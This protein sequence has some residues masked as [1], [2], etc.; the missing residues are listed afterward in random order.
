MGEA[1]YD[2][3]VVGGGNV[4]LVMGMYLTKYGGAET[5]ILEERNELGGSWETIENASPGYMSSQHSF[6]HATEWWRLPTEEDFPEFI[7]YGAKNLTH[8]GMAIAVP[9]NDGTATGIYTDALDP[10][11]ERTA[12]L[13][14]RYSQKDAETWMNF[15]EAW[16]KI[17]E[18]VNEAFCTVP[19]GRNPM[20]GPEGV[21]MRMLMD[22]VCQKVLDPQYAYMTPHNA[23]QVFFEAPE[24]QQLP[25][26]W[27][28]SAGMPV[29]GTGQGLMS[30]VFGMGMAHVMGFVKGG[31]HNCAHAAQRVIKENGGEYLT[32]S[33]V[34]D[35][36]MENGEAAGVRLADGTEIMARKGVVL[37]GMHPRQV[38]DFLGRDNV[39]PIIQRKVASLL[40]DSCLIYWSWFVLQERP[41]FKSCDQMGLPELD[42]AQWICPSGDPKDINSLVKQEHLRGLGEPGPFPSLDPNLNL[43]CIHGEGDPTLIPEDG[44]FLQLIEQHTVPAYSRDERWWRKYHEDMRDACLDLLEKYTTNVNRKSLVGYAPLS[45]W[46]ITRLRNF[47]YEGNMVGLDHEARQQGSYRPIPEFSGYKIPWVKNLCCSGTCWWPGGF[48]A[49]SKAYNCYK[50]VAQEHGLRNPGK[51]KGRPY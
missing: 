16:P 48:A 12:A 5:L 9:F 37:A 32:R 38:I 3:I 13:L 26:R 30:I 50:V 39:S 33:R 35:L 19:N 8:Q 6:Y 29:L 27:A 18:Y 21:F 31:T 45:P 22:P 7:E 2:Y 43:A 44:K 25:L 4:G 49:D 51:E 17:L 11:G 10:T 42:T 15:C 1:K 23:S 47:D 40:M 14:G 34:T 46:T 28:Y 20:E 24:N 41:N 36:I